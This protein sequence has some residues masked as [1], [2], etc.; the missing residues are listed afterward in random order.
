MVFY[1]CGYTNDLFKKG[2]VVPV[3]T[4]SYKEYWAGKS[5]ELEICVQGFWFNYRPPVQDY[6]RYS[7]T[8]SLAGLLRHRLDRFI[9]LIYKT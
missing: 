7:H 5:D 8:Y 6:D 2:F 9:P 3:D 1:L 4:Y